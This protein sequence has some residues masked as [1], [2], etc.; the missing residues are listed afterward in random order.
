M[1]E[2]ARHLPWLYCVDTILNSLS[3]RIALLR[4]GSANETGAVPKCAQVMEFCWKSCVPMG[5]IQLEPGGDRY[6]VSRP[7]KN[8]FQ[9]NHVVDIG[10]NNVPVE[11]GKSLVFHVSMQWLITI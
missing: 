5:V 1:Y 7:A 4:E 6:K 2:D 8:A 11:Y 3:T 9:T 10:K